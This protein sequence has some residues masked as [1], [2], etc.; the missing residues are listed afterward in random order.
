MTLPEGDIEELAWALLDEAVDEEHE[1][2]DE[3]NI[4]QLRAI[5]DKQEVLVDSLTTRSVFSFISK[6]LF[7]PHFITQT[8][9]VLLIFFVRIE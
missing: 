2:T 7:H 1:F 5:L 9:L 3:I 4:D 8:N 6:K